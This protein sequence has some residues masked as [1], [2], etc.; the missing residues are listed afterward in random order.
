M[1][2][3]GLKDSTEANGNA[4]SGEN[5][6]G[7]AKISQNSSN[8]SLRDLTPETVDKGIASLR[9]LFKILHFVQGYREEISDVE[10][11]Y[12]LGI[13]QHAQIEELETTVANLAFRKDQEMAKLRTENDAYKATARQIKREREELKLEKASMDD[14]RHAMQSKME[15]QKNLEIEKAKQDFSDDCET[16][17][18]EVREELGK[19]I[20]NLEKSK[21]GLK[22]AMEKL[23]KKN[24]QV[25]E[26]L[27]Q[28][29]KS[30]E[31]DKRS[32][33]SHIMRLELELHQIKAASTVSPQTPEF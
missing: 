28:Q 26:D 20:Q 5:G 11:I 29:K 9:Q 31:L 15:R 33:Q 3:R 13:T 21:S 25:Q 2:P 19:K 30:L 24:I 27:N 6:K 8:A 23:E 17:V 32:S 22:D 4:H 10:S 12:D 18:N 7:K 14:K 1:A 16:T